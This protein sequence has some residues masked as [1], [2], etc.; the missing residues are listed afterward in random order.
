MVEFVSVTLLSHAL[1][2]AVINSILAIGLANA[3]SH[4]L[5]TL[6]ENAEVKKK[7]QFGPI[8]FEPTYTLPKDTRLHEGLTGLCRF[9]NAFTH[10]KPTIKVNGEEVISGSDGNVRVSFEERTRWVN[11]FFELPYELLRHACEQIQNSSVRLSVQSLLKE[12]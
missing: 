4:G 9:R 11:R 2:E 6:V 5:F 8:C 12:E 7:W 1:C 10:P 3:K